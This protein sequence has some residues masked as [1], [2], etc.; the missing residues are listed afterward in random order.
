MVKHYFLIFLFIIPIIS[1]AQVVEEK[2][3]IYQL[4]QTNQTISSTNR[5]IITNWKSSI[6][7]KIDD[8]KVSSVPYGPAL[9]RIKFIKIG[10]KIKDR[11]APGITAN[12]LKNL[13]IIDSKNFSIYLCFKINPHISYLK[14]Y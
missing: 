4:H 1:F 10:T 5:E 9:R 11:N 13:P 8:K 3:K 6:S 2:Q 12:H 7:T 14:I